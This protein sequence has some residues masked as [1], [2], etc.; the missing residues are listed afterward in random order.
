MQC[1]WLTASEPK[2]KQNL[3]WA[4][5]VAGLKLFHLQ[6]NNSGNGERDAFGLISLAGNIL[7]AYR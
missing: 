1:V 6:S 3:S 7:L 5:K 4:V 2:K